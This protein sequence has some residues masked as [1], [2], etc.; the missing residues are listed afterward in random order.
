MRQ[1]GG[2]SG[3]MRRPLDARFL[4]GFHAADHG[5]IEGGTAVGRQSAEG[6]DR[7]AQIFAI[8]QSADVE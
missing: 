2:N 4:G 1:R 7:P 5:Q 3:S 6:A 8:I